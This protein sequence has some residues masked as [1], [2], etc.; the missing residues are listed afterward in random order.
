[1]LTLFN[2]GRCEGAEGVKTQLETCAEEWVTVLMSGLPMP[3]QLLVLD[4]DLVLS[5]TPIPRAEVYRIDV[6]AG[7]EWPLIQT[8]LPSQG[9]QNRAAYS[10]LAFAQ[11]LIDRDPTQFAREFPMHVLAMRKFYAEVKPYTQLGSVLGAPT[12]ATNFAIEL[13]KDIS[14]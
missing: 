10:V 12:H 4:P 6:L 1:M 13:F 11:Y 2:L 14:R 8:H 7:N 9:F 5:S 3:P